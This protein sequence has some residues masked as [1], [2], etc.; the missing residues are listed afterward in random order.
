MENFIGMPTEDELAELSLSELNECI[1][2]SFQQWQE[3]RRAGE[4]ADEK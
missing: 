4:T 3:R 2:A 1:Q